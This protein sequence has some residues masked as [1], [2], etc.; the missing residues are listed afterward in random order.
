MHKSP[1]DFVFMILMSFSKHKAVQFQGG[2][3]IKPQDTPGSQSNC[4][5]CRNMCPHVCLGFANYLNKLHAVPRSVKAP[6]K[7]LP[8]STKN[9]LVSPFS[10]AGMGLAAHSLHPF[11]TWW[12]R[13]D[14]RSAKENS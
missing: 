7:I 11:L 5:K 10:S 13:L 1:G 14:L 6:F 3:G 4:F 2:A 8:Q 12:K 9:N